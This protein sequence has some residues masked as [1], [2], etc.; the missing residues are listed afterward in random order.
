MQIR[1][2][3]SSRSTI[4]TYEND[5][6]SIRNHFIAKPTEGVKISYVQ[7][8]KLVTKK[9]SPYLLHPEQIFLAVTSNEGANPC[10]YMKEKKTPLSI[11][12]FSQAVYVDS[13]YSYP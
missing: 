6:V 10:Y 8:H 11:K 13:Q 7:K 3:F 1:F 5:E 12:S 4:A 9:T 2:K